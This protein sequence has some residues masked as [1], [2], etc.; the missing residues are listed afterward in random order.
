VVVVVA[1]EVPLA[2]NL[3]GRAEAE[4]KARALAQAQSFSSA[5]GGSIG[6]TPELERAADEAADQAEGRVTIVDRRGIVL[7]DSERP[8]VVGT[9]YATPGRPEIVAALDNQPNSEVR[10]SE[11]LGQDI[12]ATAVPIASAEGVVGALRITQST[13]GVSDSVTR[14]VLG[15]VAIGVAGLV[16]GLVL[17]YLLAGSLSRPLQRLADAARRLGSGDLSSRT[18]GVG[19]AREVEEL[20]R[21]FDEMAG[22]MEA[23]VRAQREFAANASHQLR[24]PLAGMKLRLESAAAGDLPED[25]RR[26][27]QAAEEE[28]DRLAGI[29]D[30]LL[31][32][33]RRT[34]AA[35]PADGRSTD[36]GAARERALERWREPAARAGAT[37]SARGAGGRARGARGD[38]DQILDA[39][40][41]NA[42]NY[43]GGPIVVEAGMDDGWGVVAVEDRGPGVPAGELGRVTERFYRAPGAAA[44]GSGLGLAIVRELAERSG[45]ALELGPGAEGGLRALVRLPAAESVR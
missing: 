41:D 38:V 4:L 17:A 21:S 3:Q 2:L 9:D 36:L 10:S 37:L 39:L 33:A 32:T 40:I 43:A 16:G 13:E 8:E 15:L 35:G 30:R 44:G 23:T 7:V 18:E 28:V 14:T 31:A 45:G 1:L 26:Q 25:A 27:V 12:L 22:R 11:E 19:G 5:L 6:A 20:A 24:T 34:E 42:I 29:V